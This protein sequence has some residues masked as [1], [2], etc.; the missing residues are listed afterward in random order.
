MPNAIM[1]ALGKTKMK[2]SSEEEPSE[3]DIGHYGESEEDEDIDVGEEE[4]AACK[5]AFEAKDAETYCKA[6]KAFVHLCMLK[7]EEDE[8]D[9]LEKEAE[10]EEGY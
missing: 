5:A 8:E 6:L 3:R 2:K 9:L 1:I 10:E 4:L 7:H